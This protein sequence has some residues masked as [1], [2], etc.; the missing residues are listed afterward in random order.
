MEVRQVTIETYGYVVF[1]A[2]AFMTYGIALQVRKV[3]RRRSTQD[4]AAGKCS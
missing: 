4:I 2:F 3:F 1:A